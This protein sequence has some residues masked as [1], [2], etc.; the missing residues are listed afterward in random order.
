M[1]NKPPTFSERK[2]TLNATSL[3]KPVRRRTAF[4]GKAVY[5]YDNNPFLTKSH[6]TKMEA[7]AS[8]QPTLPAKNNNVDDNTLGKTNRNAS[9]DP[10]VSTT[11][12]STQNQQQQS[13]GISNKKN[14]NENTLRSSK[15]KEVTSISARNSVSGVAAVTQRGLFNSRSTLS[16]VDVT[17]TSL[18][19]KREDTS[20]SLNATKKTVEADTK[21]KSSSHSSQSSAPTNNIKTLDLTG[22]KNNTTNVMNLDD[23]VAMLN[24]RLTQWL[25]INSKAAQSFECQ[26][27]I[28]QLLEAWE[29]LLQ[30]QKE[31]DDAKRRFEL[32]KEIILLQETLSVQRDQLLQV[33][34]D[35]ENFKM[36]YI[37]FTSS[38]KNTTTAM[39]ISNV[40]IGNLDVLSSQVNECCEAISKIME[41]AALESTMI[42]E[43]AQLMHHLCINMKEEIQELG[44]CNSL[45]LEISK[46]ETLERSMR[47]QKIEAASNNGF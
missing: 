4:A 11:S 7:E 47:I 33:I 18:A 22:R 40:E 36:R 6:I 27:Q 37:P 3:S 16:S 30:K 46:A 28:A 39:P 35:L 8:K 21:K 31:F 42:H 26:Q 9:S 1:N 10:S 32:K 14:L 5:D 2:K 17:K 29:L 41:N 12:L 45:I 19:K 20:R 38:L 34:Q 44:I 13:T 24:I 23:E 43:I 25:F 15:S